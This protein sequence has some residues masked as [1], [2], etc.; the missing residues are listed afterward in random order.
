MCEGGVGALTICRTPLCTRP[1]YCLPACAPPCYCLPACTPPCYCLPALTPATACLP[2]LTPATA[3]LHSPLL[4]PTCT[5]P[6]YC[7]PTL[8]P[9]TAYMPLK[10]LCHRLTA[11]MRPATACLPAFRGSATVSHCNFMLNSVLNATADTHGGGAL[12]ADATAIL[13]QHTT[14][15]SNSANG[16]GIWGGGGAL[17]LINR[18]ACLPACLPGIT[19]HPCSSHCPSLAAW[20]VMKRVRQVPAC[21]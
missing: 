16:R 3:C 14:L 15:A 11:L 6:C 18:Y 13:L 1:F 5:H 7:L 19:H 20:R 2:A 10:G 12:S 9:A 17:L 8:T 21:A 4:L